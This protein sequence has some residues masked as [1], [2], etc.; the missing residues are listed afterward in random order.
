MVSLDFDVVGKSVIV[1]SCG[2]NYDKNT[3]IVVKIRGC[4]LVTLISS[5]ASLKA[6]LK[7]SPASVDSKRT[8]PA[9]LS[10]KIFPMVLSSKG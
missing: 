8:R 4:P 9:P 2:L 1:F 5:A 3:G 10:P 7:A 6:V